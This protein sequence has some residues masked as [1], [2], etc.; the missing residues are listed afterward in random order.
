[1]PTV[2]VTVGTTPIPVCRLD[3]KNAYEYMDVI[4]QN[5]SA[6]NVYVGSDQALSTA[7]GLKLVATTGVFTNDKRQEEIWLVADG[8]GSDVRVNYVIY[9]QSDRIKFTPVQTPQVT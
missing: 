5:L 7:S 6:N 1:M 8:A 3:Q 2:S 9:S 4:I